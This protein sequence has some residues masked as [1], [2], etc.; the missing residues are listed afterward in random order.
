MLNKVEGNDDWNAKVE[1]AIVEANQ[2][3]TTLTAE[4]SAARAT[5][6]DLTAKLALSEA[7]MKALEASFVTAGRQA[8]QAVSSL[9]IQPVKADTTPA[10]AD[11]KGFVE[12]VNEQIK[13]GKTKAAAITF[14]IQNFPKEYKAAKEAGHIAKF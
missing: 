5:I 8:S 7:N 9:G 14:C 1:K 4:N 10:N 3:L 6:T 11:P 2:N 13:G 12:L